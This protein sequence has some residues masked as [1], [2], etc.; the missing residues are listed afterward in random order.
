MRHKTDASP[1]PL[2]RTDAIQLFDEPNVPR[3][4]EQLEHDGNRR[5]HYAAA[6][7]ERID[8]IRRRRADD[9]AHLAPR[10]A[11]SWRQR[12]SSPTGEREAA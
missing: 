11:Q 3:G 10:P 1:K 2:M 8:L 4:M 6:N 7:D 9:H 12:S 5:A